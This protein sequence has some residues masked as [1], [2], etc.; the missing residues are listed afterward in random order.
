MSFSRKG[1]GLGKRNGNQLRA[2][3]K[4]EKKPPKPEPALE[5]TTRTF[6]GGNEEAEDGDDEDEEPVRTY[7]GGGGYGSYSVTRTVGRTNTAWSRG[8]QRGFGPGKP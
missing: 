4:K 5:A 2:R 6:F 3:E 7:G 8:N 1:E